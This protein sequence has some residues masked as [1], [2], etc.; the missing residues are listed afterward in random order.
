MNAV[1]N[2]A[3]PFARVIECSE[4]E[5]FDDPCEIASLNPSI[6]HEMIQH[7]ALHAW[8]FHPK[9]GKQQLVEAGGDAERETKDK[10]AGKVIHRLL[11]QKG[12]EIDLLDFNDF[13]SNDAK[14]ARDEA[15]AAGRV[16]V[17]RHQMDYFVAAYE[18]LREKLAVL[19]YVFDGES[20]V[21]IEWD[22]AGASGPVRCRTRLDHLK[23]AGRAVWD[24]KKI[25]SADPDTIS[26]HIYNFGYHLKFAAHVSAVS[27]LL[28]CMADDIEYHLLFCEINPPYA[29]TPVDMRLCPSYRQLGLI[30]WDK[31]VMKWE[32]SLATNRWPE[33]CSAPIGVEPPAYVLKKEGLDNG[34]W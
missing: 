16:P 10:L 12:A 21:A 8:Q 28:G 26:R 6:A 2:E 20:E 9:L 17:L 18:V 14:N 27:K 13:R 7:T 22:E 23:R 25:V 32:Q 34:T 11:L 3:V 33:Y 29:V 4:Q 24:L 31:A 1:A 15:K 19:G 30:D 5:Y